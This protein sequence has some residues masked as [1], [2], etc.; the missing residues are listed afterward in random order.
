M[1]FAWGEHCVYMYS[2]EKK[3]Q[4]SFILTFNHVLSIPMHYPVAAALLQCI[5]TWLTFMCEVPAVIIG[6]ATVRVYMK[7]WIPTLGTDDGY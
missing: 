7:Y 1:N 3:T 5:S 2:M 4:H 6:T